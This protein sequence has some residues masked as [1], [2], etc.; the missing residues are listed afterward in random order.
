MTATFQSKL[1]SV[2]T[3][4]FSIMS[5]LSIQNKAINLGQG[6]PDF[7]PDAQLIELVNQAMLDGYNQYPQLAGYFELLVAISEK[8]E[9]LYSHQYSP[10]TEITITSGAT[11]ALMSSILALC[12]PGDEV[13]IIEPFYD[14]YLPAV[15]LAG[16]TPVV[17]SMT[18]PASTQENYSINWDTVRDALSSRTRL[19]IINTPHNPTTMILKDNDLNELESIVNQYGI[20]IISD[21]VYEHI[22]FHGEKHLSMSSRPILAEKS[23][24]ISS[25]GKTYHVTGWKIGYCAAPKKIM[26]EIRKVHQFTVFTVNTPMQVALSQYMRDPATYINLSTFYEEKKNYLS[27]ELKTKTPL[28]PYSSEGSFFLLA[29]YAGYS[30]LNE[31]DFCNWLTTK[32]RVTAIPLSAFY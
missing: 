28:I 32:H 26:T 23:V 30:E 31:Y 21:E 24:V 7:N 15:Q 1:P 5:Q 27:N 20:N 18:P 16:A 2:G 29:S 17:V 13:I 12:G 8:I 19:L 11:E 14:L 6:Y 25:F 3:T 9:T 22:V 10:E 4:I